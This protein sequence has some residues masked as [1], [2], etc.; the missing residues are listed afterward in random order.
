[1]MHC[2]YKCDLWAAPAACERPRCRGT[3]RRLGADPAGGVERGEQCAVQC[4]VVRSGAVQC[5]AVRCSAVRCGTVRWSRGGPRR[6]ARRGAWGKEVE[7]EGEE[8]GGGREGG[9]RVVEEEEEGREG[10]RVRTC[11][12]CDRDRHSRAAW[13]HFALPQAPHLQIVFV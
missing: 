3:S 2:L 8:E 1:M 13:G 7:E 10:G 12:S 4:C 9:G 5:C 11:S 6:R